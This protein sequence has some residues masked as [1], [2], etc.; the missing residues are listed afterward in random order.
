[1][2]HLPKSEIPIDVLRELLSYDPDT[3][4]LYWKKRSIDYFSTVRSCNWWNTKWAK[5]E[6]FTTVMGTGYKQGRLFS[7]AFLA[8]RVVVAL[9]DGEWPFEDVDHV[10]KDKTNN[11]RENLLLATRTENNCR[12]KRWVDNTSGATGVYFDKRRCKWVARLKLNSKY[13]HLGVF[14]SFAEAVKT[15]KDANPRY[16][17]ADSHGGDV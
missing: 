16:G 7:K 11:R 13:V 6:A 15:R 8:H 4:K 17:F 14:D 5:K 1:M 10:D 3:G 12:A 2:T 9:T